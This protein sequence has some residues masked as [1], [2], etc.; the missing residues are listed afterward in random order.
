MPK[1]SRPLTWT[2]TS[3]SP[4]MFF[5]SALVAV[6]TGVTS[7]V[8]VTDSDTPPAVMHQPAQVADFAAQQVELGMLIGLKPSISTLTVYRPG[9]SAGIRNTPWSFDTPVR[10]TLV[11]TCVAVTVAPGTTPTLS[12]TV[13]VSVALPGL[14]KRGS[15]ACEKD[16]PNEE[17][18]RT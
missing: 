18:Q 4:V 14:R 2:D 8:I 12:A 13:P 6:C 11:C 5:V 15:R 3:V 9:C 1:M 10:T 17:G 7:A 16:C